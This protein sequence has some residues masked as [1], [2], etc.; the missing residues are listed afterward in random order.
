MT[1]HPIDINGWSRKEHF[2][3]YFTGNPCTYSLTAELDVTTLLSTLREGE[4]KFFPTLLY[5]ISYV[6]NRHQ[7]FRMNFDENG[8]LGYFDQVNPCYTIFHK[9]NETFSAIWTAY[10]EEFERFYRNYLQ[11]M[12]IYS[13]VPGFSPKQTANHNLFNVSSIP[14]TSFSSFHLNLQKGYAYLPP[15]F[16]IGRYTEKDNRFLM[17]LA[18]QVH[19]AVCDGYHVARFLNELQEWIN[20]FRLG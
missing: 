16:T 20:G 11:D 12:Q 1:F 17:P 7:E 6:V 14:W 9:E 3:A 19:H 10:D 4:F 18:V 5:G 13:N 2:D 8:R 15:I